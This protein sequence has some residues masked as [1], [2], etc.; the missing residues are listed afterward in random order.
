ML[1]IFLFGT[2]A[3][4]EEYD[5]KYDNMD[6]DDVLGNYRLMTNYIK[7]LMGEGPCTPDGTTLK[8]KHIDFLHKF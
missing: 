7:C 8:S 6:L 5:T 4:G 3:D 1:V 2:L